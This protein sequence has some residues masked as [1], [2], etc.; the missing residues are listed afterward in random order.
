VYDRQVARDRHDRAGRAEPETE[1]AR[2]PLSKE[3]VLSAAIKLADRDGI[4][5]LTMRNL[6]RELGAGAMSLYHHVANKD[7]LLDAMVDLVVAEIAAVLPSDV[8]GWKTAMRHRASAAHEVL[9]RHRW[10]TMLIV[11][12]INIGPGMSRYLD[13]TLRTLREAG[14]SIDLALDA[15]HAM[16]SHIYGFTLQELNLPFAADEIPEMAASFVPQ[17][18]AEDYPY[19]YEAATHAMAAGR[20]ETI[21]FGLDLI[22]DGLDRLRDTG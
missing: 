13:S 17:I 3:R 5:S 19:A 16:D 4:D 1:L 21:E 22:L 20:E 6:A 7:E 18:S 11:S 8:D 14:F 10:A 2:A 15:W 9:V 12:R